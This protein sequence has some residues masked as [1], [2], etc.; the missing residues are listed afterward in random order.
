MTSNENL[1]ESMRKVNKYVRNRATMVLFLHIYSFTF[2][3]KKSST[4]VALYVFVFV[5]FIF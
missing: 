3:K 1:E 4:F 2:V 5:Q